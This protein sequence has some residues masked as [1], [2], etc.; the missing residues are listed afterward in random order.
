M[1]YLD[2]QS[3]ADEIM[4]DQRYLEAIVTPDDN[5]REISFSS[6]ENM[7]NTLGINF[8]ATRSGSIKKTNFL[9]FIIHFK[10][11]LPAGYAGENGLCVILFLDFHGSRANPA[12]LECAYNNH[13]LILILP[14]KTSIIS[15]PNDN[16]TNLSLT[17]RIISLTRESTICSTSRLT[18]V[19][20]VRM[21]TKAIFQHICLI[22]RVKRKS[23]SI[24]NGA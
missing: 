2:N 21:I 22:T 5:Q 4:L 17:K 14:S 19:Q 18:S 9:D 20:Y 24:E 16:G 8:C 6:L 12:A 7:V 13:I 1:K 10:K 11:H 23:T 3:E 15:Q